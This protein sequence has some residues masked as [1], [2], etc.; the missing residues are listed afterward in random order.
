MPAAGQI[1][2]FQRGKRDVRVLEIADL[3]LLGTLDVRA[4]ERI[5]PACT[6]RWSYSNLVGNDEGDFGNFDVLKGEGVFG[7]FL[8]GIEISNTEVEQRSAGQ[9]FIFALERIGEEILVAVRFK[10]RGE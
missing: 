6:R 8:H 1:A 3:L 7:A 9:Q 5:L 10:L 4:Y 2:I